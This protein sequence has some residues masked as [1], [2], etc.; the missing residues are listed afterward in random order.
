[1]HRSTRYRIERNLTSPKSW[2][3][4]AHWSRATFASASRFVGLGCESGKR[5]FGRRRD[6]ISRCGARGFDCGDPRLHGL[7][8]EFQCLGRVGCGYRVIGYDAIEV[9]VRR[10][11]ALGRTAGLL[12][13][14][15]LVGYIGLKYLR[16]W[17]FLRR[18]RIA[19]ISSE[20]LAEGLTAFIEKRDPIWKAR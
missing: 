16:R 5:H 3:E 17:L 15:I 11:S 19:R 14:A 7:P 13:V 2:S 9:V 4:R 6:L 1:M 12:V 20:D 10:V 8:G 18:L